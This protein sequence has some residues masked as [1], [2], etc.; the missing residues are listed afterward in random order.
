MTQKLNTSVVGGAVVGGAVTGGKVVG[1]AVVGGFV[2]GGAVVGGAVV[3]GAVVG[4][5]VVGG[6]VVEGDVVG[7]VVVVGAS[8][9]G[10][11]KVPEF[12]AFCCPSKSTLLVDTIEAMSPRAESVCERV[13][14]LH[15][16]FLN[17]PFVY[18]YLFL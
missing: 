16:F 17:I 4:G 5:L 12:S 13:S 14:F 9:G 3:G 1:G 18:W 2:V 8:V 7:G 11:H 15:F 6:V 10:L